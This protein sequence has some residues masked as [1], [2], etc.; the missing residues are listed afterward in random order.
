M[1]RVQAHRM[2]D[3]LQEQTV[4]AG[5]NRGDGVHHLRKV[6]DLDRPAM[7]DGNIR[8]GR[9]GQRIRQIVLLLQTLVAQLRRPRSVPDVPL[10]E[11]DADRVLD[12]RLVR[13]RDNQATPSQVNC[14]RVVG[15][16]GPR[17]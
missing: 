1:L 8:I 6:R 2:V 16:T 12:L 5:E 17:Q 13:I 7:T 14:R 11:G 15:R 4:A 9:D 3:R 10:V